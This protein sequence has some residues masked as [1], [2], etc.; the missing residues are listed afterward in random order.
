MDAA[1]AKADP[2]KKAAD[3]KKAGAGSKLE[4]IS[5]SRPR[6]INYERDC[7]AENNG[8]SL[9]VT[10]DVAIKFSEALLSLQVFEVNKENTAEETLIET[11]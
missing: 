1:K 4:D 7:V 11:I 5:D 8:M 9:E 3:P 2:K 10:E 6:T